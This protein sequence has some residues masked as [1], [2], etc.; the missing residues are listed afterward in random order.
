MRQIYDG[1]CYNKI[2]CCNLEEVIDDIK[3]GEWFRTDSMDL[4]YRSV[5]F[6]TRNNVPVPSSLFLL[7]RVLVTSATTKYTYFYNIE[8]DD[9][10]TLK[11]YTKT[12]LEDKICQEL[13]SLRRDVS[14]KTV[15]PA[16]VKKLI[17]YLNAIPQEFFLR[18]GF[19]DKVKEALKIGSGYKGKKLM[20]ENKL[21]GDI[22]DEK[23][24]KAEKDDA[25]ASAKLQ[26]VYEELQTKRLNS[27]K[28]KT[29]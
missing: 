24:A 21:V 16:S 8:Q 22:I 3:D 14:S 11:I 4:Y 18:E 10:T 27:D 9:N 29:K 19:G 1:H 20:I 2:K 26:I 12:A 28:N 23:V 6:E 13:K 25:D 5:P 7:R 15:T 17:N